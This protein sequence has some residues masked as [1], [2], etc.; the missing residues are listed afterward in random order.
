LIPFSPWQQRVISG[1]GVDRFL[2][3]MRAITNIIGKGIAPIV[4]T[5]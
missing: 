5:R 1:F 2:F 3:E 4:V